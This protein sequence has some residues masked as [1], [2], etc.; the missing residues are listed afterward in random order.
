MGHRLLILQTPQKTNSPQQRQVR[1]PAACGNGLW[2]CGWYCCCWCSLCPVAP[3]A[4]PD[5]RR[6]GIIHLRTSPWFF[7]LRS[8]L[9]FLI[10]RKGFGVDHWNIVLRPRSVVRVVKGS[11]LRISLVS[12]SQRIWRIWQSTI[13]SFM[14]GLV[15]TPS[16]CSL[17]RSSGCRFMVQIL[18][19]NHYLPLGTMIHA[20]GIPHLQTVWFMSMRAKEQQRFVFVGAQA[21]LLS[22][23]ICQFQ[24][25]TGLSPWPNPNNQVG[26]CCSEGKICHAPTKI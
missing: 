2:S 16:G 5:R 15:E 17:R 20:N 7:G 6:Q 24:Q 23:P 18:R 4:G 8:K 3:L 13:V 22:L 25:G 9:R 12:T 26:H 14:D 11:P 19:A 21:T 1:H 10:L